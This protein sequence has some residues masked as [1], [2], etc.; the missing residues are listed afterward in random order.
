MSWRLHTLEVPIAY[1]Y[2]SQQ[3]VIGY[4]DDDIVW[5]IQDNTHGVRLYNDGSEQEVLIPSDAIYII[6]DVQRDDNLEL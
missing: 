3:D 5:V 1:S 4:A 2:G 6:K